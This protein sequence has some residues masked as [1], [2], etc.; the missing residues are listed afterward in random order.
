MSQSIVEFLDEECPP[1]EDIFGT[2]DATNQPRRPRKKLKQMLTSV[3]FFLLLGHLVLS[4]LTITFITQNDRISFQSQ[5]KSYADQLLDSFRSKFLGDFLILDALSIEISSQVA[6]GNMIWPMVTI[7]DFAEIAGNARKQLKAETLGLLPVV[8]G[9]QREEWEQYVMQNHEWI[10][11]AKLWEKSKEE[12]PA[13]EA[14]EQD[15]PGARSEGNDRGLLEE[16]SHISSSNNGSTPANFSS[17]ISSKIFTLSKD[18]EAI[19]DEGSGPFTPIWLT[20]PAPPETKSINY[21]LLSHPTF[22]QAI[23]SAV[24]SRDAVLSM[25]LNI[26]S[27]HEVVTGTPTKYEYDPISAIYYPVFDNNSE[28]RE[29]VGLLVS[30]IAWTH[31][32]EDA[33]PKSAKGLVCVVENACGQTFSYKVDGGSATFLGRGDLHDRSLD[34]MVITKGISFFVDVPG[35]FSAAPF[36]FEHCPF[37]INVYPSTELKE[38]HASPLELVFWSAVIILALV[39]FAVYQRKYKNTTDNQ[40][41]VILQRDFE[42]DKGEASLVEKANSAMQSALYKLSGRHGIS[43]SKFRATTKKM[44]SQFE[45]MEQEEDSMSYATV[46]FAEIAGFRRWSEGKGQE[47][48]EEIINSIVNI[49]GA[50]ADQHGI[51]Q[52]ETVGHCFVAISGKKEAGSEHASAIVHFAAESRTKMMELFKKMSA[53]ELSMR[54]GLNSGYLQTEDQRYLVFGDTVETGRHMLKKGKPNKI[55]VSV[56]TAELLNLEGNSNW[57]SPRSHPVVIK[58]IG[59]MNSFWIKTKYFQSENS[60]DVLD[61][62]STATGS[63]IGTLGEEDLW[64]ET[65]RGNSTDP[66]QNFDGRLKKIVDRNVM[67]LLGYLKKIQARRITMQ[68]LSPRINKR[69]EAEINVGENMIEE[70]RELVML[71]NF[72]SNLAANMVNSDLVVLPEKVEKEL[73][74]YVWSI[75]SS[76]HANEFHNFEHATHVSVSMNK[77]LQKLSTTSAADKTYIGFGGKR[78]TT[79]E[80]AA[81]LDNRSFGIASD[82]L[83]E[84][85]LMLSSLVHDVDHAGISN[86]QLIKEE[87]P[88][89]SLYKNKSVAEQ[90]SVDISWWLLMTPNFSSLREAIYYDASEK[91]RFRQLLVNCVVATDIMDRDMKVHRDR[92]WAKAFKTSK[93]T[94][95]LFETIK[96]KDLQATVMIEHMIQAADAAHTMQNFRTYLKWNERQFEEMNK[97][98]HDGRED[99]DPAGNWYKCELAFFD[100]VVIPLARRLRD[101]G[102]FGEAGGEYYRNAKENRDIWQSKGKGIVKRMVKSY[103]QKVAAAQED[104]IVFS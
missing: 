95:K 2:N 74:L 13:M 84:F 50:T 48:K 10:R 46:M 28:D 7:P 15:I 64:D 86:Y 77:M 18:G 93:T 89:A 39:G 43:T 35:D 52:F 6:H 96:S 55:H 51:G 29:L 104:T 20:S 85:T 80:L 83:T 36:D 61:D 67:M 33:L 24:D 94:T 25:V 59:S 97:A 100:K 11:E 22:W 81:E 54:F 34:D 79:A 102:A 92:R 66:K 19:V 90:N 70:A 103:A 32:F 8:K 76:Y 58:G 60:M 78:S 99:M 91:R 88:L 57:L 75:A 101:C 82:P 63:T 45:D 1:M 14:A 87:S 41:I 56:D 21:N 9:N 68:K 47:E 40:S 42:A 62:M 44:P 72:D 71:P 53:P 30:E 12:S 26:E 73:R 17:G 31:F 3:P 37:D 4:G 27:K 69:T 5:F 65:T 23:D 38:Q 16:G 98:F 49:F